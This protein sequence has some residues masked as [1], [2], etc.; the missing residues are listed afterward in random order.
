M[1]IVGLYL[2]VVCDLIHPVEKTPHLMIM[3]SSSSA[4][5]TK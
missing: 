4:S 2:V 1:I 5:Y 3:F